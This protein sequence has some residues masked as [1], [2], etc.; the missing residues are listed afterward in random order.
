MELTFLQSDGGYRVRVH[1]DKLGACHH[2]N[3]EATV[4]G[5]LQ[6]RHTNLACSQRIARHK[7]SSSS[8]R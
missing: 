3:L 7:D 2:S 4:G 6:S 1:T 8:V 5:R